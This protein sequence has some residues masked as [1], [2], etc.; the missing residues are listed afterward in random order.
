[1]SQKT[2]VETMPYPK[3]LLKLLFKSP[4]LLYRL[5]LGLFV[6]RLFMVLTTI[7]RK[8]GKPRRTGCDHCSGHFGF[9]RDCAPLRSRDALAAPETSIAKI[10]FFNFPDSKLRRS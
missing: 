10:N 8:S 4:I 5:G 3:G 2:W 6:G 7:G 9:H 1:M